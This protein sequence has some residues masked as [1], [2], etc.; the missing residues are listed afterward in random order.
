MTQWP[1]VIQPRPTSASL[2][3]GPPPPPSPRPSPPS[4]TSSPTPGTILRSFPLPTGNCATTRTREALPQQR[5]PLVR[6][7]R[8][9]ASRCAG[10]ATNSPSARRRHPHGRAGV[11]LAIETNQ[12]NAH[13]GWAL[14][15][16]EAVSGTEAAKYRCRQDAHAL[17]L[18]RPD[19]AAG[20]G[21]AAADGVSA[22]YTRAR[23]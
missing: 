10:C 1:A 22:A 17:C 4:S 9:R 11:L 3:D 6:G 15:P 12:G 18:P 13:R 19:A 21:R 2:S 14:Q 23:A 20:R 7:P 5:F 8:P 16:E